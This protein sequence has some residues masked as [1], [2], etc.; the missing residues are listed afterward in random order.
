MKPMQCIWSFRVI[1][2]WIWWWQLISVDLIVTDCKT[3][4]SIYD[5]NLLT[6]FSI[7]REISA[8]C[9]KSF[10]DLC[11]CLWLLP[12][13]WHID[14]SYTH[15]FFGV[16]HNKE[17]S[18]W[19]RILADKRKDTELITILVYEIQGHLVNIMHVVIELDCRLWT[20]FSEA[21]LR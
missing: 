21:K 8:S 11:F 7:C 6:Q 12:C 15:H 16:I 5:E 14:L 17:H 18:R 2:W 10:N 20:K 19:T 3:P 13:G 9:S 1:T 4:L